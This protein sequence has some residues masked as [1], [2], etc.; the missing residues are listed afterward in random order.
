M[1]IA[2]LAGAAVLAMTATFGASMSYEES[3]KRTDVLG[4]LG[5]G[6]LS[7]ALAFAAGMAA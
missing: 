7:L 3:G 5:C 4:M 6:I 1:R 2:I